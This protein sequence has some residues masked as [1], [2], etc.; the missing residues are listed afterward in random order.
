MIIYHIVSG[1]ALNYD[2][3]IKCE[4]YFNPD[5]ELAVINEGLL[6]YLTFEEKKL[7]A[8]NIYNYLKKYGGVWITCDVTPKK[9]IQ[10]QDD[11]IQH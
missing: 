2:D 8:T 1:N 7:V 3:F 10:K 5:K 9:F 6:R 4:K 11:K